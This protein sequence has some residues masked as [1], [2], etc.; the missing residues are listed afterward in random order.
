MDQPEGGRNVN[1]YTTDSGISRLI[2]VQELLLEYSLVIIVLG[3]FLFVSLSSKLF[4][5]CVIAN[6]MKTD[7][8]HQSGL[9]GLWTHEVNEADFHVLATAEEFLVIALNTHVRYFKRIY[10]AVLKVIPILHLHN[11]GRFC[12]N[13]S[14]KKKKQSNLTYGRSV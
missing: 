4:R 3:Y 11:W 9:H 8:L 6:G 10:A 14:E 2:S 1:V 13:T 7:I 12:G 5:S